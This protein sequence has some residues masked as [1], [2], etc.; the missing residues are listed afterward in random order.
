MDENI[1][2]RDVPLD[3]PKVQEDGVLLTPG[4]KEKFNFKTFEKRVVESG[5]LGVCVH[6]PL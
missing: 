5:P 3:E 2:V 4:V 1:R 6:P